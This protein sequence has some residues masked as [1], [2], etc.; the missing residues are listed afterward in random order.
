MAA[1]GGASSEPAV[2]EQPAELSAAVRASIERKRQRALML[3]QAR[4]A[5]R[6]YPATAAAATGG[7][8]PGGV[9]PFSFLADPGQRL[10]CGVHSLRVSAQTLP[11]SQVRGVGVGSAQR[12]LSQRAVRGHRATPDSQP[13]PFLPAPGRSLAWEC[14]RPRRREMPASASVLPFCSLPAASTGP[15]GGF[16]VKLLDLVTYLTSGPAPASLSHPFNTG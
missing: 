11:Q 16:C 15:R 10:G 9:C 8:G 5:A 7:L 13:W 14:S 3:R 4:L 1:A 6:P 2:S 12:A